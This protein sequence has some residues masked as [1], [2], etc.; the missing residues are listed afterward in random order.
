ML[1]KNPCERITMEEIKVIMKETLYRHGLT[2]YCILIIIF[3]LLYID[4]SM[5]D[6]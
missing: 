6:G 3:L 1:T 4:P 2:D 5:D